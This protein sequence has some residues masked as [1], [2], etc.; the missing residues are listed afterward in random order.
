MSDKATDHDENPCDETYRLT[1]GKH[2]GLTIDELSSGYRQFLIEKKVYDRYP[3]CKAALIAAGYLETSQPADSEPISPSRKRKALEQ[4]VPSS[5]QALKRPALSAG[6]D[7]KVAAEHTGNQQAADLYFLDFGKHAGKRLRDVPAGYI[8]WIISNEVYANRP[9]LEFALK[10]LGKLD[11]TD[12]VALKAPGN[13]DT[14]AP[15]LKDSK[16]KAPPISEARDPCF[17]DPWLGSPLWIS[18]RD[19][20][21]YF[22]LRDHTLTAAGVHLVGNRELDACTIEGSMMHGGGRKRWL[23][24]VFACAEHFGTPATGTARQ[25]LKAFLGKNR[26]RESEIMGQL[27][28][29]WG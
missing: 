28:L 16:W 5:P 13:P 4:S 20:A 10:A 2:R 14:T 9:P 1:F 29:G 18:D 19:A 23:Y 8:E 24:P 25:A 26:R 11:A 27:G 21:T 3:D 7:T 17:S 6:Q 22:G 12:K 15:A